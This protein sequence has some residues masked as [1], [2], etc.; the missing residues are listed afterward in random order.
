MNIEGNGFALELKTTSLAGKAFYRLLFKRYI[1][2]PKKQL[3][4]FINRF[5]NNFL[6]LSKY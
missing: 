2:T 4:T 5:A 3:P 1:R 6:D